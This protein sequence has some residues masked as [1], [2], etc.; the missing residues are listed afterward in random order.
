MEKLERYNSQSIELFILT[1]RR[2]KVFFSIEV[3]V[4]RVPYKSSKRS[5]KIPIPQNFC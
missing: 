1:I 5:K 2:Q 3:E 4:L